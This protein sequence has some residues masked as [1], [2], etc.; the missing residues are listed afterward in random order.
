M[1]NVL[2]F[3]YVVAFSY[4]VKLL[5][6]LV[7]SAVS[8]YV[9]ILLTVVVSN[10]LAK[11]FLILSETFAFVNVVELHSVGVVPV[12]PSRRGDPSW[13]PPGLVPGW[14]PSTV[15]SWL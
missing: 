15:L 5:N 8:C 1:Y 6:N 12:S 13:V 4:H 11:L 7:R 10:R 9:T 14:W 3:V 2:F